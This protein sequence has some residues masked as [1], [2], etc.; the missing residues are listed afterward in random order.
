MCY[1][2]SYIVLHRYPW[3]P[4]LEPRPLLYLVPTKYIFQPYSLA[5]S[6]EIIYLTTTGSIISHAQ[7]SA[8]STGCGLED[9]FI[10][11]IQSIW[12]T[13]RV[14][15]LSALVNACALGSSVVI[16]NTL[17]IMLTNLFLAWIW[18]VKRSKIHHLLWHG[19]WGRRKHYHKQLK[20]FLFVSP[21]RVWLG[22]HLWL[23]LYVF[24]ARSDGE[25]NETGERTLRGAYWK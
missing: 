19:F 20:N 4:G 1:T 21:R 3:C 10:A 12:S 25:V 24:H 5:H 6:S 9:T 18:K 23:L 8:F 16:R 22:G 13:Y 11:V 14:V 7:L 15:N 17:G 2:W